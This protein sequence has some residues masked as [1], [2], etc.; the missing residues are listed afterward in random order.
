MIKY[1]IKK[2][3]RGPV[4]AALFFWWG[5]SSSHSFNDGM[6]M[7][8]GLG[9]MVWMLRVIYLGKIGSVK[10]LS[11]VMS[12]FVIANV[13]WSIC[14]LKPLRKLIRRWRYA[15]F[16]QQPYPYL[17]LYGS[18]TDTQGMLFK[19]SPAIFR[20]KIPAVKAALWRM[21]AREVLVFDDTAGDAPQF[22]L[23]AWKDSPSDGVD[24]AFERT[25]YRF[26]E[27]SAG[28]DNGFV[29]PKTLRDTIGYVPK[30]A[31]KADRAYDYE[32]QMR[33]ADLLGTSVS[34]H[35]YSK[36][37]IANM[38]GMKRFLSGLPASF[39][40]SSY[41]LAGGVAKETAELPRLELWRVWTEYVAF[42]YVFGMGDSVLNKLKKVQSQLNANA[43]LS[44]ILSS[45]PHR[46]AFDQLMAA[47][48]DATPYAEDS[49][50]AY[51]GRLPLAWHADEIYDM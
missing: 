32:N 15:G 8:V 27:Q 21:I 14:S 51:L 4:L 49:A 33:F 24:Q 42:G 13:L 38:Y 25:L 11:L 28:K 3:W 35:S 34:V 18:I 43:T 7:C 22:R 47:A 46:K 10:V 40:K 20:N 2:Y 19:L 29:L 37:E 50:S 1:V 36:R 9:F 39:E 48:A 6:M 23:K 5:W 26:L 44:Q 17:S 41:P 30:S 16:S 12:L 45:K 31:K